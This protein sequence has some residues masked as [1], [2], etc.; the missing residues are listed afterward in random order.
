MRAAVLRAMFLRERAAFARDYPERR[1]AAARLV[2][3]ARSCPQPPCAARDYADAGGPAR[4][5]PGTI[6]VGR[7]ILRLSRYGA[8]AVLLHEL[9]HLA[10]RRLDD[11]GREQRA[12]DIAWAVTGVRIRYGAND[13]Q[14]THASGRWPRPRYLPR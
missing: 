11:E 10:D 14:T 8:R 9:G 13:V 4:D 12:D 5:R 6:R 2:I 1:V 7:R 3:V